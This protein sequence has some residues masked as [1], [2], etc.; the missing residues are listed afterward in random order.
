MKVEVSAAD[1]RSGKVETADWM[2]APVRTVDEPGQKVS[3]FL[4]STMPDGVGRVEGRGD[5]ASWVVRP[6]P[7]GSPVHADQPTPLGLQGQGPATPTRRRWP[8]PAPR[9][10][11]TPDL[12]RTS[13]DS[14]PVY[15][16]KRLRGSAALIRPRTTA[17]GT[18]ELSLQVGLVLFPHRAGPS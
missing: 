6:L 8:S 2:M 5:A 1:G 15:L 14:A 16:A 12:D 9:P 13:M 10:M 11:W 4:C 3:G 18:V 7:G 17:P